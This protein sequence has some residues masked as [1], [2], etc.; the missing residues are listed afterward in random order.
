MDGDVPHAAMSS[1]DEDAPML[2]FSGAHT[3]TEPE[4][5]VS[6]RT[7]SPVLGGAPADDGTATG[8]LTFPPVGPGVSTMEQDMQRLMELDG[9]AN[10][11]EPDESRDDALRGLVARLERHGY[12]AAAPAPSD[13]ADMP[14]TAELAQAVLFLARRTSEQAAT[15]QHLQH[16][17]R[18]TRLASL[19]LFSSLR[20][21]Y[22][23]MLQAERDIQARL[24][25][26]LSGS[27]SQSKMLSD[28]VARASLHTPDERAYGRAHADDTRESTS[29]TEA[30]RTK[31]LADKRYLRQRVADA[32]AQLARVKD[33]LKG[34]RP[35]L[36]RAAY[37]D[38]LG[39]RSSPPRTLAPSPHTSPSRKREAVL[40]DARAEHL[41][42]ASRMLRTLRHASRS[43]A[44]GSTPRRPE[45]TPMTPRRTYDAYP[46]TPR[47]RADEAH[48]PYVPRGASSMPPSHSAPLP[49]PSTPYT[50]GLDDLLHAAESLR[51]SSSP[52]LAMPHTTPRA[53]L[54]PSPTRAVPPRVP[55]SAPRAAPA[56]PHSAPL[57]GSPKRRRVTAMDADDLTAPSP[58]DVLAH[59]AANEHASSSPTHGWAAPAGKPRASPSWPPAPHKGHHG[60]APPPPLHYYPYAPNG[61]PAAPAP[62]A[63]PRAAQA[64][65]TTTLSPEKRLPYVRWS[66]E[67]DTKLRRAIKE[68]GQRWEHVAR[69]VG[70]R[71]YHQCR[72]RYLLMRRKEAAANGTASPS[73]AA[74]GAGAKDGVKDETP[75]APRSAPSDGEPS[76]APALDVRPQQ[77]S[78][79]SRH[80]HLTGVTPGM[81]AEAPSRPIPP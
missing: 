45:R 67:E 52:S 62:A 25:V 37:D 77:C 14:S 1:G 15:Q 66:A 44:D 2:G 50:S 81:S 47:T 64:S 16:L 20:L 7:P 11:A 61:A 48:S 69:A 19:S 24:E 58:L 33:E 28:M 75:A 41:L 36:L 21:S 12:T 76:A 35:F 26:E 49:A 54:P 40:G 63:T 60:S 53:Y 42:L 51:R 78:P 72:Q 38:E 46:S 3:D 73:R 17:V 13:A 34:L 39:E 9:A 4:K 55:W 43:S 57:L 27:K 70:S 23:H 32:E 68:H 22:A 74:P 31:L 6:P 8:H 71:S 18:V 56:S 5:S 29:L 65:A 10:A 30:E 80:A 79:A 59:H